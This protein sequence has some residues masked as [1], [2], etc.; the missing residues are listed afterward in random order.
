MDPLPLEPTAA[1]TDEEIEVV[2][3]GPGEM[4]LLQPMPVKVE[5]SGAGSAQQ[6]FVSMSEQ[7]KIW[8]SG[9]DYNSA[10]TDFGSL[11]EEIWEERDTPRERLT[12]PVCENLDLLG[13]YLP[14]DPDSD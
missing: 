14:E 9:D 2:P 4:N 7:P 1:F 3:W 13:K 8:G 5:T 6:I 10:L 11:L 12:K